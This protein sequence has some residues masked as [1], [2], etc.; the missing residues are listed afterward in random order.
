M[1]ERISA[2]I[3]SW[4]VKSLFRNKIFLIIIIL[5]AVN[6]GSFLFIAF[7]NNSLI[8]AYVEAKTNKDWI[9]AA[10]TLTKIFW[11]SYLDN[12][13]ELVSEILIEKGDGLYQN[14]FFTQSLEYFYKAS[15]LNN[16]GELKKE[17]DWIEQ[18]YYFPK[19]FIEESIVPIDLILDSLSESEYKR[20]LLKTGN[21]VRILIYY[22]GDPVEI[23]FKLKSEDKE[24]VSFANGFNMDEMFS[25]NAFYSILG[26]PGTTREG[27]YSIEINIDFDDEKQEVISIPVEITEN[28]FSY[29]YIYIDNKLGEILELKKE[30]SGEIE[31]LFDL[32]KTQSGNIVEHGNFLEPIEYI[33]VTSGFGDERIFVYP[34]GTELIDYHIGIDYGAVT[35]T[36]V[37]SIGAGRVIL[38]SE[39]IIT[40][41]TLAIEHLPG[42]YSLYFHLSEIVVNAGDIVNKGE[43]IC[44]VGNS[45]LST[46]AHLHLS[47]SVFGTFID[48]EYFFD[49]ELVINLN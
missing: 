47:V 34:D 39:Y 43:L 23:E 31:E 46:A 32:I 7:Y 40:G 21:P 42:V 38:C 6:A 15:E 22:P 33:L 13:K 48:P 45:G 25:I 27:I 2:F 10:D 49:N 28:D 19:I 41:K 9:E 26:V 8:N 4:S 18:E 17:I 12:E 5:I 35:G 36:P 14:Y 16:S 1:I 29:E 20:P 3:Y 30:A 11:Y 37:Y 44:K 24:T